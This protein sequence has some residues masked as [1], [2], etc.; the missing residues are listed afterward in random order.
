MPQFRT[1]TSG[2]Q[3]DAC[4]GCTDFERSH[5]RGQ[6]Q[7]TGLIANMRRY[8]LVQMERHVGERDADTLR[9]LWQTWYLYAR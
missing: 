6:S 1:A 3:A 8:K 5:C 4:H 7:T 9:H 2:A